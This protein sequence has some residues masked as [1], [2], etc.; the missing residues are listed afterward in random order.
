MVY[1]LYVYIYSSPHTC[2]LPVRLHSLLYSCSIWMFSSVYFSSLNRS[3]IGTTMDLCTAELLSGVATNCLRL[4]NVG[5]SSTKICA[6]YCTALSKS[7]LPS[8]T[9]GKMSS[10]VRLF[11]I[12][13]GVQSSQLKSYGGRWSISIASRVVALHIVWCR[14]GCIRIVA[15]LLNMNVI[16]VLLLTH[17][18]ARVSLF[19]VDWNYRI[20]TTSV[21]FWWLF[22]SEPHWL[23][24][25]DTPR[26]DRMTCKCQHGW[27]R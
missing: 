21:H 8:S 17:L 16:L 25:L 3:F 7:I 13:C 27:D 1:C 20:P 15:L 4:L 14:S 12:F 23:V 18:P 24:V 6:V 22:C 19:G 5:N 10:N 11:L 26:F 2:G 9:L